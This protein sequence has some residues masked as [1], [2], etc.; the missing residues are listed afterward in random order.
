MHYIFITGKK[1]HNLLTNQNINLQIYL[2]VKHKNVCSHL[3]KVY[4][5][6]L[7][8]RDSRKIKPPIIYIRGLNIFAITPD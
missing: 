3:C 4:L 6:K 8:P 5:S 2:I 7:Q 1:C